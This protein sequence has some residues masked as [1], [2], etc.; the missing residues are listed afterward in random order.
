MYAETYKIRVPT[1]S[2][3]VK[4]YSYKGLFGLKTVLFHPKERNHANTKN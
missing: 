3:T 1:P 2:I 4:A